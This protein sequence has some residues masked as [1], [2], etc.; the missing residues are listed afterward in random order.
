MPDS[1][2]SK[3]PFWDQAAKQLLCSLIVMMK[4]QTPLAQHNFTGLMKSLNLSVL[5][6][7]EQ[8]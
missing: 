2:T 4:Y 8:N 3:E 6:I 7:R 5:G 1:L